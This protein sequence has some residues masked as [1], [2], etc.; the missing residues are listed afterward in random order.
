VPAAHLTADITDGGGDNVDV[1]TTPAGSPLS[2]ARPN[3]RWVVAEQ[4]TEA[5]RQRWGM[6]LQAVGV[7][8]SL[9]HGDDTDS[10]DVAMVAVTRGKRDSPRPGTRRIDGVVVDLGVI[11]AEEYLRHAR[12]L[13]TSW[14]L[15]ADQYITT[16]ALHDPDAWLP[17]LRDTHL[18]LL[19]HTE[20]HVFASLAREAWCRATTAQAKA[21]RMA[22]WYETEA[23]MLV[24]AEARLG[25]AL[26]DGLLTRTYFRNSADAVRKTGVASSH[27]YE[28]GER[29]ADQA[30]ELARRGRP[31]DG[32]VDDLL[33][34]P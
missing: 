9:A 1:P 5:L 12:T 2:A 25:V 13:T 4:V 27:I 8:G 16:K 32:D 33:G 30:E 24:L 28:L 31:V 29:L 14:P 26:V 20:G 34:R 21:R 23:A 10:S 15:A 3:P 7:H 6:H 18:A 17:Q 19:A 11:S 22:E